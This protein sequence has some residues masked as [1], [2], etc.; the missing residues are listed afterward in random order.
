[1]NR[2][3][4][5]VALICLLLLISGCV[6]KDNKT[7]DS[8]YQDYKNSDE[9]EV[10][11][12]Y[13]E[14]EQVNKIYINW[15]YGEVTIKENS[16]NNIKLEEI[17]EEGIE[18][19]YKGHYCLNNDIL[20]IHFMAPKAVYSSTN[21]IK[22]LVI[23][24]GKDLEGIEIHSISNSTNLE[25]INSY[26]LKIDSISGK[27][28][29]KNI[30]ANDVVIKAVSSETSI[31]NLITNTI[32]LNNVSGNFSLKNTYVKEKIQINT[33]SGNVDLSTTYN[34]KTIDIDTTSGDISLDLTYTDNYY[35][36]I[37]TVLEKHNV[38]KGS[39]DIKINIKTVSGN[40][41]HNLK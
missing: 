41:S 5:R 32:Y 8:Y 29:L 21:F 17:V 25:N 19:I 35:L 4:F 12:T 34:P 15:I 2:N 6:I 38:S 27:V 10:I 7:Y 39:D 36:S 11:E 1:M 26:N 16:N 18:D 13:K 40:V 28:E 9:Y 23:S 30:K 3:I 20:Y 14:L 22:H 24:V 37:T 31:D 33:V